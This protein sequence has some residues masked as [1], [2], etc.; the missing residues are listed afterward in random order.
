M[1]RQVLFSGKGD[2]SLTHPF[3]PVI[4]DVGG[5]GTVGPQH[6]AGLAAVLQNAE[7]GFFHFFP[8]T[9]VNDAVLLKAD[10]YRFASKEFFPSARETPSACT[11][12][13]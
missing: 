2:G 8:G 13:L 7:S 3:Q 1:K 5:D 12:Q 4:V 9:G 6:D 10:E 11:A